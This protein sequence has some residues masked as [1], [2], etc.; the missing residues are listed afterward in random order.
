MSSHYPEDRSGPPDARRQQLVIMN[1]LLRAVTAVYTIDELFNWLCY[2]FIQHFQAELVEFWTPVLT[3]A[4]TST[5]QLRTLLARDPA[6]PEQLTYNEQVLTIAQRIALE[7]LNAQILPIELLFTPNQLAILRHYRLH[8]CLGGF[9]SSPLLLPPPPATPGAPE[10]LPLAL[11]Y[12]LFT[13][14]APQHELLAAITTVLKQAIG[15]AA[16]RGLL[17]RPPAAPAPPAAASPPA[18]QAGQ[19][20]PLTALVPR[21][22]ESEELLTSE[23]PF[24]RAAAIADKRARR[25]HAAI[26]GFQNIAELAQTT[27]MSLQDT[28]AALQV[29]VKMR[30]VELCDPQGHP[31]PAERLFET[32]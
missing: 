9:M 12:L 8:A 2:A 16:G 31:V 22:R 3:P 21:R 4:K 1:L 20:A 5:L 23:N 17:L 32:P 25:L 6:L 18:A 26:D 19:P 27:G 10:P 28:I 13:W 11:V 15:L 29:L 7:Q 30:R 14:Y 24:A